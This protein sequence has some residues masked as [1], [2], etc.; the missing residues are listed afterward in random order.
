MFWIP[1]F[2]EYYEGEYRMIAYLAYFHCASSII[3]CILCGVGKL[4]NYEEY[5]YGYIM[6]VCLIIFQV[7]VGYSATV[8]R[9]TPF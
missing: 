1:M 8:A 7:R 9:G 5:V 2:K 6:L 4:L 3:C